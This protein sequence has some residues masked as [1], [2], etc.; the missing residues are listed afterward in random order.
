MTDKA[1]F[2]EAEYRQQLIDLGTPP[3]QAAD[4]A[5]R[6]AAARMKP[7]GTFDAAAVKE[8]AK[9]R[10][11]ASA[12]ASASQV[13]MVDGQAA[14]LLAAE[15]PEFV[16]PLT[17][18][19]SARRIPIRS[20][21]PSKDAAIIAASAQIADEPPMGDDLAFLHGVLC[22]VGLPR[23][24]VDG[25]EFTRQSGSAALSIQAGKLWNGEEFVQQVVPYGTLPRLILAWMNTYAVRHKTAEIPVGDSASEFMKMLGKAVT[26]GERGTLG[27][28]KK[29]VNALAACRMT[30]GFTRGDRAYTYD[31]KPISAFESWIKGENSPQKALWP[32][33][34]VYSKD[35]MQTLQTQSVPLD[36]RA[37]A[38][39]QG[40]A[41]AMD[42]YT[43]LADRLH[44]ITSPKG[45]KLY[46]HNAREQFGQE[47][48]GKEADKDFKKKFVP[49]MRDALAVYPAARVVPIR[50]GILM[51][52]SA[53]PIPY[54]GD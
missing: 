21:R 8:A 42:V 31:G 9:N 24:K 52:P 50:G 15:A 19:G 34:V 4:V 3:D 25:N 2:N 53:P 6:T 1:D 48:T 7:A 12:P 39:L 40:S 30:L 11:A 49:A 14:E 27:M 44:R 22:Q 17:V 10:P 45:V 16:G 28:F 37:L 32:G 43:M 38:Q 46:W 47:Y 23:S 26:G 36:W 33:V 13:P 5:A 29:Q 35:Y 18:L 54:K 20:A 51:L 41:L